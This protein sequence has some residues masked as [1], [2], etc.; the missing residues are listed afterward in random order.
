MSCF[1]SCTDLV[2]S[3]NSSPA[4]T[5]ASACVKQSL[6]FGPGW[7]IC[8]PKISTCCMNH[9]HRILFPRLHPGRQT[10]AL[11]M[12]QP[13][14]RSIGC[15]TSTC[16]CNPMPHRLHQHHHYLLPRYHLLRH[17]HP[18]CPSCQK[19]PQSCHHRQSNICSRTHRQCHSKGIC[20]CHRGVGMHKAR[21]SQSG[22]FKRK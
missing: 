12:D 8:R 22:N 1:W 3:C 7:S 10:R 13:V 5:K 6:L 18:I 2:A 14:R 19:Q 16:R 20:P 21:D 4:S 11:R 17:C 15:A 9:L